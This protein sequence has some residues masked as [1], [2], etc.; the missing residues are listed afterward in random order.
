M[1]MRR[2]G[3]FDGAGVGAGGVLAAVLAAG[4]AAG[5]D[6]ASAAGAWRSRS[7][8]RAAH[9]ILIVC[10]IALA[11][12]QGIN[13]GGGS[14]AQLRVIDASPDAPAIDSYQN[15]AALAYNLGFGTAT[16]YV[17]MLPGSYLL[18]ADRAGTRQALAA[19][20]VSLAAGHQY[21][22]IV[23]NVDAAMQQT[24][25]LDQSTPAPAGEVAVRLVDQAT[26]AGAVEVYLVPRSG[27]LSTTAPIATD[28]S[29]GSNSG[30]LDLPA[31]I[32][33]LAVV[34]AGT[35]PVPSTVTLLS[36]A[37]V[38]YASG[39][40]RTLVLIDSGQAAASATAPGLSP[41]ASLS[42]APRAAVGV[43]AIIADDS[44]PSND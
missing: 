30:Y 42:A 20:S 3:G 22:A 15:N 9:W 29:F 18:A 8:R 43:Q 7:C 23:G 28:L 33:E 27:K 10:A 4:L 12:C 35:V 6:R 19:A 5:T 40:V 44:D 31:G 25:L 26:R 37:Q 34:P 11:G 41:G 13:M 24:L 36:G 2:A 16:S 38:E 14:V 39:A 21:T 17:A 32:Y 1:R